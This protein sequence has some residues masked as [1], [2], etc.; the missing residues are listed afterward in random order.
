MNQEQEATSPGL[1]V[2]SASLQVLHMNR[3]AM[4]LLKHLEGTE[5]SIGTERTVVAPLQQHC[6]DIIEAMQARLASNNWEQFQHYCTIGD[7]T[8]AIVLKKFGLIDRRGLPHSRIVLLLSS[9]TTASMSE[10]RRME[11]SDK[12]FENGHLGADLPQAIG[13]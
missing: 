9:H 11:S 10:I 8:R 2:L 7:S 12:I 5:Q 1:V 4:A 3:R 13:M 6:Q